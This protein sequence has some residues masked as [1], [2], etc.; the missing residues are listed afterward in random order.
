MANII[1]FKSVRPSRNKVHLL[2]SRPF[3]TYK[4]IIK[5]KLESNPYSFLHVINQNLIKLKN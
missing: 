4:R 5:V 3:Y 1:P 2:C